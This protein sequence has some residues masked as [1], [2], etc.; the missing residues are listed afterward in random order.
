MKHIALS[1]L[2][3]AVPA[4]GVALMVSQIVIG[5]RI[6]PSIIAGLAT[7]AAGLYSKEQ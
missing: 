5:P 6:W 1:V 4:I 2:F 7:F 3:A